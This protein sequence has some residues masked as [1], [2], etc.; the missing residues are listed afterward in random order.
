MLNDIVLQ[1]VTVTEIDRGYWGDG[2]GIGGEHWPVRAGLVRFHR[3]NGTWTS[4]EYIYTVA[5]RSSFHQS[6][7]S[8]I[9]PS[10]F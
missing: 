7:F 1:T 9:H 4:P 8:L 3:P 5:R 2:A 10:H 6:C